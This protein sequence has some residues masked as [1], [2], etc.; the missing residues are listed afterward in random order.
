MTLVCA[1]C[2]VS[3][4]YAS[5]EAAAGLWKTFMIIPLTKDSGWAMLSLISKPSL[6][7]G[8]PLT[9]KFQRRRLP[10][11]K[12]MTIAAGF[13]CQTGLVICA[14]TQE[15]IAGYV[16]TDTDKIRL[17]QAGDKRYN[18][19]FTGAGN[20][21]L[22]DTAVDEI[23]AALTDEKP[24]GL[25]RIALSVKQTML[26]VFSDCIQPYS[27]FPTDDRPSL[28]ML[29]GIQAGQS[30][31]LYKASGTSFSALRDADCIGYGIALGKSLIKQL[32]TPQISIDDAALVALY[33]LQQAKRWVDGCGGNSDIVLLRHD[34]Q[35]LRMTTEWIV[36]L[37]RHFDEFNQHLSP[38]LIA[39]ADKQREHTDFDK[40]LD[41]FNHQIQRLRGRFVAEMFTS[42]PH[43]QELFLE[44]FVPRNKKGKGSKRST[45]QTSAGPQ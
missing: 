33:V 13:P 45:S 35:I 40:I 10:K 15:T 30:S 19:V 43:F 2:I 16:K 44:G 36:S 31:V 3:K 34:G 20:G 26:K 11:V 24:Q 28:T 41:E 1:F 29:I 7:F 25:T 17:F 37:E 27:A 22:I 38:L 14:D 5:Q 9:L 4:G 32:F 42:D 39:C 18:I 23:A 8:R 6:P 21:D 12:P